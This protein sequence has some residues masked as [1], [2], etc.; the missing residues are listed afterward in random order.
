MFGDKNKNKKIDTDD[1]EN[2]SK[3]KLFMGARVMWPPDV[4]DNV[5]QTC[6]K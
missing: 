1:D 4:S 2:K 6:I 3:F 5:L